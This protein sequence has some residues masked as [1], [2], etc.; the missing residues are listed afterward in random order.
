[1]P[2]GSSGAD[3][4]LI[5]QEIEFMHTDFNLEE[6][7]NIVKQTNYPRAD[8][9]IENHILNNPS[10]EQAMAMLSNIEK[11]QLTALN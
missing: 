6:A 4:L 11:K 9:F 5:D 10:R 7:A 3:W 1:M 8:Y 2:F